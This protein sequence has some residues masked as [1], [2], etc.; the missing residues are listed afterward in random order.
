GA[1]AR[2]QGAADV[3]VAGQA[4]ALE[5][6]VAAYADRRAAS[7]RPDRS[8]RP[9]RQPAQRAARLEGQAIV[10]RC[11]DVAHAVGAALVAAALVQGD[12]QTA[13]SRPGAGIDQIAAH[14]RAGGPARVH[15][16]IGAVA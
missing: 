12:V 5:A 4:R 8:A 15:R 9:H 13:R 1:G 16:T 14:L 7:A 3:P 2:A 6:D 10:S 11:R